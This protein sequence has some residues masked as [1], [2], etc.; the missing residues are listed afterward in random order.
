LLVVD[1]SRLTVIDSWALRVIVGAWRELQ[2]AGCAL[3]LA[4]P[5]DRAWR[6]VAGHRR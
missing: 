5:T 1:M 2:A 3:A 4:G 6:R